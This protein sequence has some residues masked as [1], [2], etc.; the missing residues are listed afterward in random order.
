[1]DDPVDVIAEL[2]SE[3]VHKDNRPE[4]KKGPGNRRS[5]DRKPW[6]RLREPEKPKHQQSP[7][8]KMHV[9]HELPAKPQKVRRK[10]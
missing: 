4:K 5:G 1:M 6:E 9:G 3:D 8:A 10:R 2:E 7:A